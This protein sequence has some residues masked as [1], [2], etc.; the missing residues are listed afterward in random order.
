VRRVAVCAA[1][2]GAAIARLAANR[3]RARSL[4]EAGRR[5]VREITRTGVVERVLGQ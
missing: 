4:G 1:E 3:G 5:R 2:V